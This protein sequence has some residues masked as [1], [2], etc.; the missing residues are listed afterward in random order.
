[1]HAPSLLLRLSLTPVALAL[2]VL[3]A[4]VLTSLRAFQARREQAGDAR[5]ALMVSWEFPPCTATGVHLPLSIARHAA[6][7]GWDMRVVC[8]PGPAQAPAAGRELA[9]AVPP[10]VKIARVSR[11]LAREHQVRFHPAWGIPGIDGGWV[12]A[13]VMALTAAVRFWRDRPDVVIASGPRFANFAAARRLAE[14]FGAKLLLQYRD[15][16]TVHTPD[17]VTVTPRDVTEERMCLARADV[18]SFVSEGKRAAYLRAFPDL[19]PA[20]F[21]ITPN[22]WEPYFHGKAKDGT[23]HL[24][25]PAGTF[26]LTYT[27]RYHRS[28]ARL[29]NSC[30]SLLARRPD[31]GHLRLVFVGD[32]LPH[33]RALMADFA[34]RNPN[35]LIDLPAAPPTMAIEIQRESSALLLA[36]DH[37]YDGVV[38]LKTF[39]Y[40]CSR[41]PILVFGRGG[42][43]AS[44]VDR[45]DAG[46]SVP[47]DDADALEAAIARLMTGNRPWDTPER[48]KWCA[49]HDRRTLVLEMLATVTPP[50]SASAEGLC[51][52]SP[53]P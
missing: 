20:K 30:E 8:G 48:K 23:R 1:M 29:L 18:V 33:N 14:A 12:A 24:P 46:I 38:P 40:M 44:I 41:Q 43:A 6:N 21:I 52:S 10:S 9:D 45:M 13:Q 4:F 17:F 28:F 49:Q 53:R 16:W 22:G 19:D 37:S 27:G 3:S 51:A 2:W 32:Q 42:G 35:I 15:E 39:D 26:S 11:L 25:A 34:R 7:A 47:V 36:N 50:V 31:L 5:R